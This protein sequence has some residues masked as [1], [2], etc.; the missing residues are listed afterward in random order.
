MGC[1]V[2]KRQDFPLFRREASEQEAIVFQPER[3]QLLNFTKCNVLLRFFL[4]HVCEDIV[5]HVHLLIRRIVDDETINHG[6][7]LLHLLTRL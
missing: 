6:H 2:H 1:M 4:Q 5:F 3:I 7:Q